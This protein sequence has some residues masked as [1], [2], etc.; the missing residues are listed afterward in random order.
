[1]PSSLKMEEFVMAKRKISAKELV[2]DIRSGLSDLELMKKYNVSLQGLQKLIDKLVAAGRLSQSK[3]D[4]RSESP[5]RFACPACGRAQNERYD[6]CPKCGIVVAKYN[7]ASDRSVKKAPAR[8]P[9]HEEKVEEKETP[10][11][12][13]KNRI[14]VESPVEG[15]ER[16]ENTEKKNI[17]WVLSWIFG[18]IL[19]LAGIGILSEVP[20]A[21]LILIL[22]AAILLPPVN[23]TIE[24]KLNLRL[25]RRVK[26]YL[27]VGCLI[28]F[29][30]ITALYG[31]KE[32]KK[33][34]IVVKT[35]SKEASKRSAPV[36]AIQKEIV[37]DTFNIIHSID[38]N[39][40]T[41]NLETD[42]PDTTNVMVSISRIYLKKDDEERYSNSYHS[43]KT[44]V[45]GL[46]KSTIIKIDE[47]QWFLNLK[48][49]QLLLAKM[50]EPFEVGWIDNSVELSMVVPINQP[51]PSFGERNKFLY[52][53]AV[54]INPTMKIVRKSARLNLPIGDELKN[55]LDSRQAGPVAPKAKPARKFT[56]KDLPK[57]KPAQSDSQKAA[58][59]YKIIE[60]ERFRTIKCMLTVRLSKK[61]SKESLRQLA[62]K[63]RSEE[64][65][66]YD[67]MFVTYYLPNMKVG[68]GAWA[69]THFNPKLNVKIL[70]M[71][72]EQE[73]KLSNEKQIQSG[74]TIG[75]WIDE[76]YGKYTIIK[77]GSGYILKTRYKDGSGGTENLIKY[78]FH[79]KTAFKAKIDDRG[80]YFVIDDSGGL[81][82]YDSA[83]LITTMR[84][85]K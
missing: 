66:K 34:Q 60:T 50:S 46:K 58:Y 22:M 78:K 25:S 42:L 67:R 24:R 45:S 59:Y 56:N 41:Y 29:P 10:F 55:I 17:G 52:G 2:K 6:E 30:I 49:K 80:E 11:E 15:T 16:L 5:T 76:L 68:S 13:N 43:E 28:G 8:K 70:G 85:I 72:I 40:L 20:F 81:G 44:T 39:I 37:C 7:K 36:E 77:K 47:D 26:F 38:G 65:K 62:I 12:L 9:I 83:G 71:T 51:N 79:R 18:F 61:I 33:S 14:D 35:K 27:F 75:V 32:T 63:L 64:P 73:I 3:I 69:T 48:K 57:Q 82:L 4:A 21:A 54:E 1:M 23:R 31:S 84:A 53:K 74:K 19:L